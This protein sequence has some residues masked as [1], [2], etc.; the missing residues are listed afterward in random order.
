MSIQA[1]PPLRRKGAPRPVPTRSDAYRHLSI[2]GLRDV[3]S[4]LLAE[5]SNVSYWR[6]ILQARL[7]VVSASGT[8]RPLDTERLRPVLTTERIGAGRQALVRVL[9][10]DALPPLPNLSEL[11]ERRI[12]DHDMAGQSAFA[13]DL[14]AAE[15]E[16]SSYRNALHV[17]ISEATG[18]LIAR[19]REQPSLCLTAL[20][21]PPARRASA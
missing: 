9:P 11:W 1:A 18:E 4:A 6:R 12:G 17:R 3:R 16:L 20:P 19:Y 2:D 7:D 21:L 14:Q 10:V 15:A 5:E 13:E 8:G